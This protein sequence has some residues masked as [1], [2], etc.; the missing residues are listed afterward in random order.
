LREKVKHRRAAVGA[1]TQ[2]ATGVR[3]DAPWSEGV[4]PAALMHLAQGGSVRLFHAV[5]AVRILADVVGDV[6]SGAAG[7]ERI[8]HSK[9]RKTPSR[10]GDFTA[11]RMFPPVDPE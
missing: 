10:V 1:K 4:L 6:L 9:P 11:H 7:K 2:L 8:L 5:K 3:A